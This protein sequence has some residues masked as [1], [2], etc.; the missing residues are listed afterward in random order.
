MVEVDLSDAPEGWGPYFS[1]ADAR[2]LDEDRAALRRGDIAA[3]AGFGRVYRL[4][5]VKASA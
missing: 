3:A 1:L 4:T 2:R 5:P